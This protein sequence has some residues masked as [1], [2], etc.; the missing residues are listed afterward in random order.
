LL[1]AAVTAVHKVNT[2]VLRRPEALTTLRH[3]KINLTKYPF[4]VC[5]DGTAA[6][7]YANRQ[8]SGT[9]GPADHWA[10]VLEGGGMCMSDESCLKRAATQEELTTSRFDYD[11]APTV[12]VTEH[13]TRIPL[14]MHSRV[15]IIVL[16][17]C[18]S[19]AWVGNSTRVFVNATKSSGLAQYVF[20]FRG[21]AIVEAVLKTERDAQQS[22]PVTVTLLGVSAGAL[23]AAASVTAVNDLLPAADVNLIMDSP[24]PFPVDAAITE[25]NDDSDLVAFVAANNLD[26]GQSVNNGKVDMLSPFID[27]FDPRKDD[28]LLQTAVQN[29]GRGAARFPC[30]L[31]AACMLEQLALRSKGARRSLRIMMIAPKH[32]LFMIAKGAFQKAFQGRDNG[33][34][35]LITNFKTRL[36]KILAQASVASK[37][38]SAELPILPTLFAPACPMHG[39]TTAFFDPPLPSASRRLRDFDLAGSFKFT[40]EGYNFEAVYDFERTLA[41]EALTTVLVDG[42]SVSD[43]LFEF[44]TAIANRN[45]SAVAVRYLQRVVVQPDLPRQTKDRS[46][47]SRARRAVACIRCC[48]CLL[49]GPLFDERCLDV[50][51]A[52][53]RSALTHCVPS[54]ARSSSR[55][56]VYVAPVLQNRN[57]R[58]ATPAEQQRV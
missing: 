55:N 3:Q 11:L 8:I 10:V 30:L 54:R 44:A 17:Y 36:A 37:V 40:S 47:D 34:A 43:A 2:Q 41:S 20:H 23:G 26:P 9:A 46:F 1:S 12:N 58:D 13:L 14:A 22:S 31:D 15:A 57:Q 33:D 29:V 4:A 24:P 48:G 49:H 7:Y 21:A 6:S 19:D 42:T 45:I 32:D 25:V 27:W 38:T 16:R 56:M 51:W 5:N 53:A 18:S 50:L 28:P 39:M 52:S 35:P